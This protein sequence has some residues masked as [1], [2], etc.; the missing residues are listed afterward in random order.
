MLPC[1]WSRAKMR[2]AL[3]YRPVISVVHGSVTEPSREVPIWAEVD[4]C[5]VGGGAAGVGAAVGAA[6]AGIRKILL[7]ERY[8]F[9]GG[10][11]VAGLSNTLCGLFASATKKPEF[12]TQ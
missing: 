2:S 6:R 7:I 5:I 10:A 4:L 3:P 12:I 11:N 1:L 9:C 8:G